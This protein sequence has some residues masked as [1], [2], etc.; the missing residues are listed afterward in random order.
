M[1]DIILEKR[2]IA[3]RLYEA[4]QSL[5]TPS[6]RQLFEDYYVYDLSLSEIA[7][8]RGITRSAASDS[9]KKGLAKMRSY[10]K[11]LR[12]LARKDELSAL[13]TAIRDASPDEKEAALKKLEEY[14][15]NAL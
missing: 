1:K 2:E 12:L 6:Q 8:N 14:L 9:L 15:D 7:E 13:V 4:Y 10:E 11:K 5:L 3:S